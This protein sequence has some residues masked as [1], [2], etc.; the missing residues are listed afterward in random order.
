[1]FPMLPDVGVRV[2][3]DLIEFRV[4]GEQQAILAGAQPIRGCNDRP[5][6]NLDV[7]AAVANRHPLLG[8]EPR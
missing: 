5:R 1:M 3:G 7:L 8:T 6:L 2:D 4:G